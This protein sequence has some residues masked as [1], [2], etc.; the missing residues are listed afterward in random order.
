MNRLFKVG[1]LLQV[2]ALATIQMVH[3]GQEKSTSLQQLEMSAKEVSLYF[4]QLNKKMSI[5]H[6]SHAIDIHDEI[7]LKNILHN[8]I[9]L[10]KTISKQLDTAIGFWNLYLDTISAPT[11]ETYLLGQ[12]MASLLGTVRALFLQ[13]SVDQAMIFSLIQ[14]IPE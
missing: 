13:S 12:V 11:A 2:S 4:S 3:A 6:I 9:D 7:A 1:L 5:P 8:T 14:K 10:N